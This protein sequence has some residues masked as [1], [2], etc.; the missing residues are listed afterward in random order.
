MPLM[1][2]IVLLMGLLTIRWLAAA[3]HQEENH[4]S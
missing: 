4:Q 1:L 2:R 3:Q